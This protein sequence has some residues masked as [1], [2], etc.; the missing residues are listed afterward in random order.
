MS[1]ILALNYNGSVIRQRRADNYVNLT[2]LCQANGKKVADY[3]KLK[4]TKAYLEAVST[5]MKICVSVLVQTYQGG[6]TRSQNNKVD[7]GTWAHPLIALHCA[8]WISPEFHLWCNKHI[9]VLMETGKT[10]LEDD[11]LAGDDP[12]ISSLRRIAEV[13]KTQLEQE[14]RLTA[15]EKEVKRLQTSPDDY[16]IQSAPIA[17]CSALASPTARP[18]RSAGRQP[19]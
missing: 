17:V 8:Q 7:Q 11:V 1:D 16:S 18:T 9:K 13:R 15:V 6:N 2:E 12:I 4:T 10:E 19:A 14:K 3:L 5:D